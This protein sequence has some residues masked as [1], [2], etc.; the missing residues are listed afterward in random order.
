MKKIEVTH[1]RRHYRI[2]TLFLEDVEELQSVAKDKLFNCV[3]SDDRYEYES[4]DEV[5]TRKGSLIK[6]LDAEFRQKDSDESI[7]IHFH[8]VLVSMSV[9][10]ISNELKALSMEFDSILS[11]RKTITN[12]IRTP[13]FWGGVLGGGLVTGV[14][15]SALAWEVHASLVTFLMLMA[16]AFFYSIYNWVNYPAIFLDRQHKRSTFWR[17]N[18]DRIFLL[19]LGAGVGLIAKM[20][21]DYFSK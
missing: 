10:G 16:L 3:F 13:Y 17:R 14:S 2:N 9:D 19:I 8:R 6:E 18:G 5:L 21:Y 11:A 12:T 1:R 4:T 15:L 7:R 20:L